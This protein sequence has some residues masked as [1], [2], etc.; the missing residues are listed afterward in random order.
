MAELWKF[1]I[2]EC[3]KR[4]AERAKQEL[5]Q[6]IMT[7]VYE[8]R[9]GRRAFYYSG[10][11]APTYQFYNNIENYLSSA[12]TGSNRMGVEYT[13]WSNPGLMGFD[14]DTRLH[15]IDSIDRQNVLMQQLN[16]NISDLGKGWWTERRPF[17]DLTIQEINEKL[18]GWYK[19]ECRKTGL[20][21]M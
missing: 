14:G 20:P 18:D 7:H 9:N 15:G 4:V 17:F 1:E 2:L 11:V 21:V 19:E 16:E 3:V 6:Q 12:F 5:L 10:S 8:Y 13:I